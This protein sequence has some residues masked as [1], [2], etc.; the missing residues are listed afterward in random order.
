MFN[1]IKDTY[2]KSEASVVIQNLLKTQI[3]AGIFKLQSLSADDLAAILVLQGWDVNPELLGGRFGTRPHKLLVAIFAVAVVIVASETGSSSRPKWTIERSPEFQHA[4]IN[5]FGTLMNE[6]EK[7]GRIYNF[8]ETDAAVLEI[9]KKA[10][11]PILDKFFD[12]KGDDDW[13]DPSIKYTEDEY[14][15][16][17][18]YEAFVISA[19]SVNRTGL[20]RGENGSSLID[21]LEHEPL[22]RAHRD[23][24]CPVDHGT[25]FAKQFDVSKL[26]ITK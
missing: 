10:A 6:I 16:D 23:G 7:N 22:K 5:I 9:S 12:E 24:I 1:N 25:Y 14:T 2:K 8:N 15:W 17:E 4:C 26:K 19:C 11:S 3:D 18:W 20:K 21:Y 13:D